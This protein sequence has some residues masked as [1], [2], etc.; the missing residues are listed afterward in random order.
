MAKK[1]SNLPE[2]FVRSESLLF[3]EPN[4]DISRMSTQTS[5]HYPITSIIDQSSPLEFVVNSNDVQFIDLTENKIFIK[6]QL[7][8]ADTSVLASTNIVSTVN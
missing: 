2:T 1:S 4:Y 3:Q 8:K 5:E 6:A 7:L